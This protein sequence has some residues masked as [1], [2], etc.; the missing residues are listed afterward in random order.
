MTINLVLIPPG[1]FMMGSPQ[2]EEGRDA[3]EGP[4]HRVRITN[5]FYIAVHEVMQ[6]QYE[7]VMGENPSYFRGA[8]LPVEAV[9][10]ND[11][12]EFCRRLSRKVG[13]KVRLPTEAEWEYA[14]R[15]R[16][17]EAHCFGDDPAGLGEYGWFAG[18]SEGRTHPVGEK[19]PNAWGLHD[20]HGNVWEW[21][22]DWSGDYDAGPVSDPQ[23]PENGASRVLRGGSWYIG[24][25]GCR[26]A[27]RYTYWPQNALDVA[28]FRVAVPVKAPQP[29]KR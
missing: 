28:G 24:V 16:S 13:G 29:Q 27:S 6:A 17:T 5:P 19:K 18:N 3:D 8:N 15:A 10:W 2:A 11:A 23:G 22:A 14:C 25:N 7:K 9:S 1:E 12:T 20:M 21:C 26:S 4:Q